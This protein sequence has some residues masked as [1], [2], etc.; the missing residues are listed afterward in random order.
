MAEINSAEIGFEKEIWKAADKMRGNIDASEYKSV[1]L[2]LIF[3]KYI[4]DKFEAKYDELVAEGIGMEEDKDEYLAENIFYVPTEARW[5]AIAERA[6]TPE[7]GTAIDDAMRAIE[8]ENKRL[9]DIL[10]KNFSRPELDKRRL[11]EVV[12]LF[13]NI[14]MHQHGETKDIL[15]RAYEYCLSKFAEAEGKLAGEF[16]TPACI[17]R[18]LVEVIQPY[19][20]RVYDPCCGSGGMFVQSAKFIEE[21]AHS[22]KDIS[23]YGQDSNP[24]TWKMA[25][26]NLAIRGIEA[27]LGRYNADTFFNDCHPTLKADFVMA[28]PPFNLS[29]WGADKLSDDVRWKYGTPPNGN[30]NFAW[31]QHIIHHLA[32]SGRAGIVLAN[33]SL[34][35]QSGGEGE[36][37]KQIVEADLVDCI[38]AMPSQLFYT[39]QIPVS[40]WFL[41]KDK[42]QKG[43]TLFIDARNMGTMIT[44]KLRQLT[45]EDIRMV[46][47]TVDAFEAGTLAEEKGFCAVVPTAEIAKQDFILTPGRYVGIAEQKA[48]SEPFGEKMARLTGELSGLFK[49]S[50]SLEEEIKRQLESIGYELK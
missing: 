50:H 39:T 35:S 8:R 3:L 28:N 33:G 6:H 31:I 11:G 15:G 49:Q 45:D 42:K 29:D 26:M 46:A 17:V 10:P 2:G 16:Y 38:L 48:E 30:A 20:G 25:Q 23:V 1:V 19:K 41:N 5:A 44:R 32:P 4:S 40:V 21:H 34:S 13:T 43:K 14:K 27:D 22:I 7:I 18:T 24:T 9:K 36:I 12:D 37:R 47:E